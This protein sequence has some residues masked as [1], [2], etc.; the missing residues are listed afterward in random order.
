MGVILHLLYQSDFQI[1]WEYEKAKKYKGSRKKRS[2]YSQA[3]RKGWP[4]PI[5][6]SFLWFSFGVRLTLEYDYVC[7]EMDFT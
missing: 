1:F 6:V 5:T 7:S 4:P 3:D 2:F